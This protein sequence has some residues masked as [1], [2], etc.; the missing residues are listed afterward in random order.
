MK[1]K[2]NE[3]MELYL[4]GFLTEKEFHKKRQDLYLPGYEN[5]RSICYNCLGEL[6]DYI[7]DF[8]LQHCAHLYLNGKS[9]SRYLAMALRKHREEKST[10]R[11]YIINRRR[12]V[13]LG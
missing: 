1:Q 6:V 13:S 5:L 12:G 2:H 9:T 4:Q 8:N 11:Q 7:T 10:L 3:L